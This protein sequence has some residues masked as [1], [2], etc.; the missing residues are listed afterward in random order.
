MIECLLYLLKGFPLF[1][2]IHGVILPQTVR[3][4]IQLDVEA[5]GNFFQVKEY[6]LPSAVLSVIV[7]P[8][9]NI[10]PP[11]LF[12]KPLNQAMRYFLS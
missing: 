4:Q 5:T 7:A 3:R 8:F 10:N 12:E 11:R 9:K 1:P 2:Q 6:C